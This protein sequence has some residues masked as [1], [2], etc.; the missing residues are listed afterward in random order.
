LLFYIMSNFF[1]TNGLSAHTP[2]GLMRWPV[3]VTIPDAKKNVM[4]ERKGVELS[5]LTTVKSEAV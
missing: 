5:G 3:S 1:A 4:L 2:T